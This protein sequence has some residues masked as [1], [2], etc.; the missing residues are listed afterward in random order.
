MEIIAEILL[1]VALW[2]L[3][4]LLEVLLQGGAGALGEVL[5]RVLKK[6]TADFQSV[7]PWWAALGYALFGAIMGVVSLLVF[8]SLMI[9]SPVLRMVNVVV[10]AVLTGASMAA[11]GAWRRKNGQAIMRLDTFAYGVYFGF[12]MSLVR[13]FW[14]H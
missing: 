6:P 13:Y 2:V 5:G 9:Q 1:Q 8:P 12:A 11:L 14:G 7:H 4:V 10:S 3:E